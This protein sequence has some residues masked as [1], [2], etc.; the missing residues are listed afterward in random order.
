MAAITPCLWF[1]GVAEE[2]ARF[3]AGL[4]PDSRVDRVNRSPADTPSGPAGSVLTVE[5]T[6]R[7]QP[8]LGLNGGPL[9]KFNEAVSFILDCE[10][11][12]EV[13]RYWDALGE[14]GEPGPCGWLKDRYGLSWQV[15]PREAID[16]L[17]DPDQ[18][19]AG[20]VMTAIM[21]M[22][23]LDLAELRRVYKGGA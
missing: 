4:V 5:F 19:R 2:A 7:G 3:Y 13:D 9:F 12:A 6:L 20:R 21:G 14:G 23:K 8:F 15:V 16:M 10:D 1:D 11:Q 22:G 17:R 18:A